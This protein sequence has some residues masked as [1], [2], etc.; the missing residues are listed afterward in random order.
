MPEI[1]ALAPVL[2][3]DRRLFSRNL[4]LGC[5]FHRFFYRSVNISGGGQY[6]PHTAFAANLWFAK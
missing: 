3:N 2:M 4:N 5:R 1:S 6:N